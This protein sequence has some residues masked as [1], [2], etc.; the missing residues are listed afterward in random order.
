MDEIVNRVAGSGIVTIDLESLVVPGERVVFD[1]APYL[2]M[3]QILREK[4]F[5]EFLKAHDWT[6]YKGKI[7]GV[8]CTADAI[9]PAWAYMLVAL[10]VQ[11]LAER[12]LFATGEQLESI[13]FEE[14]LAALDLEPYRD[15]RVVIKG[16]SDA[17]VPLSA[18]VTLA[19]RLR[20]V[21]RTIMFGEPCSTVPLYKKATKS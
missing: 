19:A 3:G 2:H 17:Q 20:P 16:C 7:V 10:A 1:I 5:R 11:P 6:S 18:Y 9:V 15:A 21:A 8:T 12:V 4:E 13:L 14:R